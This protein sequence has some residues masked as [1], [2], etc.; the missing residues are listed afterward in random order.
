MNIHRDE[1]LLEA[2]NVQRDTQSWLAQFAAGTDTVV[3]AP[4]AENTQSTAHNVS[5]PGTSTP[6]DEEIVIEGM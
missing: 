4:S 6:P 1:L 2:T 3:G 5:K